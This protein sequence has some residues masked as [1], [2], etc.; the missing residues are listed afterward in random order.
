MMDRASPAVTTPDDILE[1]AAATVIERCIRNNGREF[2]WGYRCDADPA[3]AEQAATAHARHID[4]IRSPSVRQVSAT[5]WSVKWWS[6][7]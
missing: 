1:R 3:R 7:D 6:V 4:Y 5:E 2:E